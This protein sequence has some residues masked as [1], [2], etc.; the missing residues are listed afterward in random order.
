[1]TVGI[2]PSED[3]VKQIAVFFDGEMR[4]GRRLKLKEATAPGYEGRYLYKV[5]PVEVGAFQPGEFIPL[6]VVG[7]CWYDERVGAYRFCGENVFPADLKSETLKLV[8]HYY[9]IGVRI[10]K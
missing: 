7:S 8:P 9:V 10:S 2:I 3:S 1:M 4:V 6:V 5:R